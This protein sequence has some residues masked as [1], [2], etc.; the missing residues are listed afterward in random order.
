M[1]DSSVEKLA[2]RP[3]VYEILR[4]IHLSDEGTYPAK[5]VLKSDIDEELAE[6]RLDELKDSGLVYE[7][8]R[9]DPVQYDLNYPA[10]R[11]LWEQLWKKEIGELPVSPV[12]FSTFMENYVKAYLDEVGDSSLDEMLVTE[13]Y[14][15]LV[16]SSD[17]N[18]P[19]SYRE[20]SSKIEKKFGG[21]NDSAEFI[22]SGL[23]RV[24]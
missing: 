21:R 5:M 4:E 22:D 10:F 3:V 16:H 15:G 2:S 1:D 14:F 20:L 11:D 7:V 23:T 12:N 24:N 13:F 19:E 18:L 17:K 6:K 8:E 9:T